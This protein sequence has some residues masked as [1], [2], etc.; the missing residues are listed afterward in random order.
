MVCSIA[1]EILL[2]TQITT[3]PARHAKSSVKKPSLRRRLV[4]LLFARLLQRSDATLV[5]DG[6]LPLLGVHRILVSRPNHRLGNMLLLTPLIA[7][8]ERVYPGAE[9]HL[10]VGAASGAEIFASFRNVRQVHCLTARVA[11]HP[12]LLWKTVR[13]LKRMRF[14]LAVDAS[15]GSQSGRIFMA[16]A[17]PRRMVGFRA[18]NPGVTQAQGTHFAE[19]PVFALWRALPPGVSAGMTCPPLSVRLS[20]REVEAAEHDLGRLTGSR[21][22]G[23]RPRIGVFANATGAKNLDTAWWNAF[24][25][26]IHRVRPDF[27][28]IEFLPA[29]AHSMLG[30][31]VTTYYS[32]Q[33]RQMAAVMSQL[34]GFVSAD[35]GVMHLAAASGVPTFGLFCAT[36]PELY[37]PY[38]GGSWGLALANWSAGEVAHRVVKSVQRRVALETCVPASD[39]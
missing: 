18:A 17:Q 7:E 10:L 2:L 32:T 4:R 35:C 13:Q 29:H 21:C 37:A 25:A 39:Q 31:R 28:L 6:K 15:L 33:L 8:I 23:S 12:W 27:E 16:L 5:S 19:R 36:D 1:A 20:N 24:I 14:D 3:V 26:E 34:A 11:R 9:I 30:C 38:A 22:P